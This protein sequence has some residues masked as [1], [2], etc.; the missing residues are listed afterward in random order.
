MR[1]AVLVAASALP[2]AAPSACASWLAVSHCPALAWPWQQV[3]LLELEGVQLVLRIT[4]TNTLAP[5]E[6]E[7]AIGYHCF[8]GRLA[9]ETQVYLHALSSTSSASSGGTNGGWLFQGLGGA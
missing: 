1:H 6:Q 7:E 5:E 8:R 3:L 2:T 4:A 9:P